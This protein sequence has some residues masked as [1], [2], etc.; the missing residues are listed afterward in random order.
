[1]IISHRH[2]FV[3]LRSCKTGST[4]T[5]LAIRKS[6]ILDPQSDI[7][8]F[9]EGP[10]ADPFHCPLNM[11]STPP[12]ASRFA[13]IAPHTLVWRN[14]AKRTM[15]L[16]LPELVGLG[17]LTARQ[18]REY[19][20]YV[21][22]REPVDKMIS[23]A[24]FLLRRA[25]RWLFKQSD[26]EEPRSVQE[27]FDRK[28]IESVMPILA[29]PQ[30]HWFSTHHPQNLRFLVFDDLP[31][32]V[33]GLVGRF[34]GSLGADQVPEKKSGLRDEQSRKAENL[35][36]PETIAALKETYRRDHRQWERAKARLEK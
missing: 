17:F 3:F 26:I 9:V 30:S 4:S 2:K 8:N 35:L 16:N 36:R 11:P 7:S 13:E 32:E 34:G 15:H 25:P 31:N 5:A 1:M 24:N 28:I 10:I 23:A 29:L 14:P 33:A 19:T 22:I 12:P 21:G 6:G 20:V 18:A 27:V